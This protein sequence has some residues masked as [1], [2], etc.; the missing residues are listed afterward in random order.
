MKSF[1]AVQQKI[2]DAVETEM[3]RFISEQVTE[4]Q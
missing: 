4:E 2:I 1:E 3:V